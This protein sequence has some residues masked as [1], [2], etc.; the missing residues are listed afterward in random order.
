[1]ALHRS[2]TVVPYR[3]QPARPSS[4][5]RSGIAAMGAF[6]DG[7]PATS[8]RHLV[9]LVWRAAQRRPLT[10][11][12]MRKARVGRGGRCTPPRCCWYHPPSTPRRLG[13]A[14]ER[15]VN[16]DVPAPG[17]TANLYLR[18]LNSGGFERA[19][20]GGTT[21]P[22]PL[23]HTFLL[24]GRH[25]EALPTRGA[26]AGVKVDYGP[27]KGEVISQ[28]LTEDAGRPKTGSSA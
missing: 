17:S 16:L 12:V 21:T 1:V 19:T 26:S 6:G 20:S 27:F 22:G 2:G 7:R 14:A 8:S 18:S 4:G 15:R 25:A 3:T 11:T 10:S 5:V 9:G 23:K 13:L 28:S 24:A